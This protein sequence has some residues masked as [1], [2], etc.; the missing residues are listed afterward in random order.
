MF[1]ST[2]QVPEGLKS[3]MYMK[4]NLIKWKK[5]CDIVQIPNRE[6]EMLSEKKYSASDFNRE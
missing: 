5:I 3:Q 4:K 1:N 6:R 2:T